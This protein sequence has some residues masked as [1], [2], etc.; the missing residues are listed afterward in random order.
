MNADMEF[1]CPKC[2]CVIYS[3]RHKVCGNCAA[4]LPK[5]LLLTEAQ[6]QA[7]DKER[8]KEKKRVRDFQL[9]AD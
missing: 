6:I 4:A 8:A 1:K 5:E 3:R 2:H 9:P 7:M